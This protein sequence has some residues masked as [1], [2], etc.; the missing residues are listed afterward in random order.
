MIKGKIP[1]RCTECR[2]IFFG[3][4]IEWQATALSMPIQ[5]PNCGSKHTLPAHA[6]KRMYEDIWKRMDENK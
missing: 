1:F 2:K 3:L 4:D 6:S 5:C